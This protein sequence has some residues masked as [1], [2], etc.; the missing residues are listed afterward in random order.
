MFMSKSRPGDVV[1]DFPAAEKP[2][3]EF[4]KPSGMPMYE[5]VESCVI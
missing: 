1:V 5:T 2:V 3:F 4:I